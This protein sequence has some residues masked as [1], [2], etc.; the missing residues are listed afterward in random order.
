MSSIHWY[1]HPYVFLFLSQINI[2][3]HLPYSQKCIDKS[4][5]S[6]FAYNGLY[7]LGRTH[8]TGV[9]Q[10]DNKNKNSHQDFFGFRNA[11]TNPCYQL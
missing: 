11:N 9:L 7:K 3:Y 4:I 10:F 1:I 2:I 5:K 6:H 8:L